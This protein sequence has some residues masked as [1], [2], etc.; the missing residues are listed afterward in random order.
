MKKSSN[1]Q[2]NKKIKINKKIK[3]IRRKFFSKI[4]ILNLT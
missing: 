3:M 4:K 1:K 2:L